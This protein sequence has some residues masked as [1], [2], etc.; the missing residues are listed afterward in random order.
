MFTIGRAAVDFIVK[1]ETVALND[2]NADQFKTGLESEGT[3]LMQRI[4]K[5]EDYLFPLF[6]NAMR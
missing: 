5:E 3:V 1:A 4:R 6:V 2:A